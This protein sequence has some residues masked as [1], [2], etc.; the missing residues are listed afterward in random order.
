[1][2][3]VSRLKLPPLDYGKETIGQRITRVRKERGL[4]QVQLADRI[5]IIQSLVS[6]YEKDKLRLSVE[7]AVR[8]ALA[9]GVGVEQ[10]VSPKSNPHPMP[11]P[12]R[13]WLRRMEQ[14][15]KLPPRR[16]EFVLQALDSLLKAQSLAG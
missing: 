14:I 12:N 10:L 7:M 16:Q 1:M 3:R 4:S 8:F 5:G 13:R 6:T 2:P 9:L 11:K 15:E